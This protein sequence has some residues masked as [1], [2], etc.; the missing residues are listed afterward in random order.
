MGFAGFTAAQNARIAAI[1]RQLTVEPNASASTIQNML[2][3]MASGDAPG[4]VRFGAGT[5]ALGSTSLT[6]NGPV[7]IEGAGEG[8]TTLTH[9]GSG[10]I[11]INTGTGVETLRCGIRYLTLDGLSATTGGAVGIVLGQG[12]VT[13]KTGAGLFQG[14]TLKRFS[15]A[16]AQGLFTALCTWVRCSFESNKDGF[17][18]E[19]TYENGVTTQTFLGCR[20][21]NNTQRGA[22]LEQGDTITFASGCQ[23]EDNGQE[24]AR[25]QHPGGA[26]AIMRDIT[27]DTSYFEDNGASGAYADLRFD[28]TS[29]QSIQ[30]AAVRRC[31]FQGTNADG[32]VW[33]G[34]GSF[35]EED[36]E[37]SPV[38]TS[39]LIASSS[40][41]CFVHSR[42]QR[43][44]STIWTLGASALTT[45]ERRA[46]NGTFQLYTN[47]GGTAQLV[48]DIGTANKIG[49]FGTAGAAKP[50]V[51][52]SR[53]GNAALESLCTAL[54]N[55]GLITNSTS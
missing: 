17:R 33:F 37:F 43:A 9:S 21:A 34:K 48:L 51:T 15:T 40:V 44:P 3:D 38:G 24:G 55:L 28:N 6:L 45:H 14:L 18:A 2:D 27:F 49:F 22:Y 50:T 47:N 1:E 5:W 31:R 12:T 39:N 11:K 46:G 13:P 53:G 36:N 23:F 7:H 20:F 52:G 32:N 26:T 19:T 42:N 4:V 10:A 29:T 25:V 41:A 35:L 16:G 8:A 54:A 30:N